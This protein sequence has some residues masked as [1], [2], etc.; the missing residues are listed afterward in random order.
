VSTGDESGLTPEEQAELER[1]QAKQAR[2][3]TGQPSPAA[4]PTPDGPP[5]PAGTAWKPLT[6]IAVLAVIVVLVVQSQNDDVGTS[7]GD[8]ESNAPRLPPEVVYELGG[9]ARSA[10]I[11]YTGTGGSTEQQNGVDVPLTTKT[12]ATGLRVRLDRGDFAYLSAQN[13]GTGSITCIIR[14]GATVIDQATSH[15]EFAIASCSG[16]VP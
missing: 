16:T 3:A 12:G 7:G 11:T 2:P 4:P 8:V 1:L 6:V 14:A 10:D 5:K 9:T 15:G 13:K